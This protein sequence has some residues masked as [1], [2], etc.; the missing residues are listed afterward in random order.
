[1]WEPLAQVDSKVMVKEWMVV[2]MFFR[3]IAFMNHCHDSKTTRTLLDY[4]HGYTQQ[5][6]I[7]RGLLHS[8]MDYETFLHQR[9]EDYYR[10]LSRNNE[11]DEKL[12]F[13]IMNVV[14][15]FFLLCARRDTIKQL[16][17]TTYFHIFYLAE[18]KLIRDLEKG[19]VI[20]S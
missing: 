7:Q 18:T 16:A 9:Y 8:D 1:M 5:A 11:P 19:V 3:S 14:D 15:R 13:Q 12:L 20:I 6:L 10:A 2:K 4:F 17:T